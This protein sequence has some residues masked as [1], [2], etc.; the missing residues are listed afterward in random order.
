VSKSETRTNIA[1]I[2]LVITAL[3]IGVAL[4]TYAVNNTYLTDETSHDLDI[5]K[6]EGCLPAKVNT[7]SIAVIETKLA[8]IERDI[9]ELRVEQKTNTTS[10]LKAI[11]KSP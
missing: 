5:L 1:I 6:S 2:S 8:N 10:I 11:E 9:A 7:T 3:V 4:V